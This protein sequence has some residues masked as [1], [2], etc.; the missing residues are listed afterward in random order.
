MY[1]IGVCHVPPIVNLLDTPA[2]RLMRPRHLK[3]FM[4]LARSTFH[5]ASNLN[6]LSMICIFAMWAAPASVSRMVTP[7]MAMGCFPVFTLTLLLMSAE[8]LQ[9]IMQQHEFWFFTITNASNWIIAAVLFSDSRIL[10][11]IACFFITEIVI[12]MDANF[13]TAISATK[14]H[15]RRIIPH[16][17]IDFTLANSFLNNNVTLMVFIMRKTFR[18]RHIL[19]PEFREDRIIPCSVLRCDLVLQRMRANDP[20]GRS[21]YETFQSMREQSNAAGDQEFELNVVN[22]PGVKVSTRTSSGRNAGVFGPVASS[23]SS[24]RRSTYTASGRSSRY[25]SAVIQPRRLIATIGKHGTTWKLPHASMLHSMSVTREQAQ[26]RMRVL[27]PTLAFLDLRDHLIR[28]F[29]PRDVL[30]MWKTVIHYA[31]GFS[32][33]LLAGLTM[34]LPVASKDDVVAGGQLYALV[35]GASLLCTIAFLLPFLASCQRSIVRALLRNFDFMFSSIQFTLACLCLGDMLRW[36]YRCLGL[37]AWLQWFHWIL[38]WDALVPTVR[39]RF[40]FK[41]IYGTPVLLSILVGLVWIVY[42]LFFSPTDALLDRA[43]LTASWGDMRMS[44]RTSTFLIGRLNTILTWSIR[45]VWKAVRSE[46]DELVLIHGFL[47]YYTPMEFFPLMRSAEI[48]PCDE[49]S[50]V[51]ELLKPAESPLSLAPIA[52]RSSMTT[53]S[54]FLPQIEDARE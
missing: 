4:N 11:C 3:K 54:G 42:S 44:I 2:S 1:E 39:R 15:F 35:P 40:R 46:E 37:L 21:R 23:R 10:G 9:Q 48:V 49:T 25:H 17:K 50:G 30:P 32:G 7:I 26:Q 12:L 19:K 51:K 5:H 8:L 53:P 29:A 31:C 13:R 16:N 52:K 47:E 38:L 27:T 33:L 34:Y 36:D 14:S 18:R 24:R 28:T 41:K 43:V 6:R 45:L 20:E 22:A